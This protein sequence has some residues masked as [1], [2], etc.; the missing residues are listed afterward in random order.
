MKVALTGH[1][2]YVGSVMTPMLVAAGHEVVGIDTDL[3]R[4]STYGADT[5]DPGV[6]TLFKDVRDVTAEDLEGV[7]AVIHLAA[8][9]NDPLGDL[10][11]TLTDE[12]NH[13][14]SVRLAEL[15]RSVGVQRFLFASSCSN[16]GA[17]VEDWLTEESAFN[18]VTPYGVS[19]VAVEQAVSKLATDDFS[20]TFL[21]SAT[22]YGVSPRLRFDLV[23]NNLTAWA[24][25]TKR[26]LLKSDGTPW[27]PIV[28]I[29]DMSRAFLA[30]LE[31]PRE[32][33]HNEA[34][35][36]GRTS[37]NFQIKDLAEIVASVVPDSRIE[38]AGEAG[39]DA[40]NYRVNC[41]KIRDTL[42][43][44][45]PTWT[46]EAGA[47]QL[48]ESFQ[49]IGVVL[50][51][52]EGPRYRRVDQLKALIEESLLGPDLRWTTTEVPA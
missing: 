8:L 9:S 48:Y 20:P 23:L 28:H 45:Q 50:E 4:R 49:Q 39:P 6:P 36:V 52:F 7:D 13:R 10:N 24:F 5:L 38:F 16:Y 15:A 22:A 46:A 18:P 17:G 42:P 44:F 29:E 34:F 31:A 33:V 32:L 40:R 12:I 3:Y 37:E 25:C 47:R 1:L 41:D 27:R 14:A 35:N 11:P 26:V 2:G 30:V 51:D 21:R 43:A 19:K